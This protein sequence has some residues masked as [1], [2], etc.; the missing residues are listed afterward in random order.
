MSE[1]LNVC[2]CMH[3]CIYTHVHIHISMYICMRCRCS[4]AFMFI[5]MYIFIYAYI[6]TMVHIHIY[7]YVCIHMKLLTLNQGD[8]ARLQWAS[9]GTIMSE[10][11]NVRDP[12]KVT[13][14]MTTQGQI[15]GFFSQLSFGCYLPEVASV[16]DWLNICPW[17]ASRASI[18]KLDHSD[19]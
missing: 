8:D 3:T 7:L 18:L 19:P 6:L 2:I 11:L 16:G 10:V 15:D 5:Y 12:D 13:A 17:V 4:H 9:R 1:V 14:L